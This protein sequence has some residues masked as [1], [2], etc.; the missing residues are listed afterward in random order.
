M[1]TL[2][3]FLLLACG[4][5][6]A[7]ASPSPLEDIP[8]CPGKG[9]PNGWICR[10]K[11]GCFEASTRI[12]MADGTE[13]FIID[14]H[15]GDEVWNP[16]T[17]RGQGV[18]YMTI[19]TEYDG[20]MRVGIGKRMVEVT[21]THPFLTRKGWVQAKTLRIG[22]Q[23]WDWDGAFRRLDLVEPFRGHVLPTVVNLVLEGEERSF[24]EHFVLANGL[25]TGDL[26]VQRAAE[27][28]VK[29]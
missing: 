7:A 10:K 11:A 5:S 2:L 19:G 18:R 26:S 12:R 29:P 27:D 16:K 21:P 1:R 28:S 9:P 25:V 8:V 3:R 6:I 20:M 22:M 15:K 4:G 14:I 13:K 23:V 17:G 24:D